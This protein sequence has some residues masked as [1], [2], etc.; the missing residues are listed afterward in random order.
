MRGLTLFLFN[1]YRSNSKQ[2]SVIFKDRPMSPRETAI[3]W[4]EYIIRHKGAPHLQSV[5]QELTWYE[6]LLLDV[7][8]VPVVISI[9]VLVVIRIYMGVFCN[10]DKYIVI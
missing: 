6:F 2:Q 9:I 7:L 5:A 1:R 10:A 3:F 4:T 8:A